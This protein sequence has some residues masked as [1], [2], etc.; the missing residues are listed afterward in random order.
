MRAQIALLES[1]ICFAM[2]GSATAALFNFYS[3]SPVPEPSAEYAA[4]ASLESAYFY[5]SSMHA[6]IESGAYSTNDSKS[7]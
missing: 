3:A 7:V 1:L 4:I 6:C 2:L 5:N